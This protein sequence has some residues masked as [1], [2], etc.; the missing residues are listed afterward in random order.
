METLCKDLSYKTLDKNAF[1]ELVTTHKSRWSLTSS[2]IQNMFRGSTQE[3]ALSR[4]RIC[5]LEAKRQLRATA[6]FVQDNLLFGLVTPL[7]LALKRLPLLVHFALPLHHLQAFLGLKT[8]KR[9]KHVNARPKDERFFSKY[10]IEG[11]PFKQ[12]LISP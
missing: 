7:L 6:L 8:R 10:K 5:L 3:G 11:N 1:T 2:S 9:R 4:W 12:S